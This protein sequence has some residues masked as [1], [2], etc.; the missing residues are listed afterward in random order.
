M[1]ESIEKKVEEL[2]MQGMGKR[3]IYNRLKKSRDTHKLTFYI[4]NIATVAARK[5]FQY[6][7]LL[8]VTPL[9]FI[10][11]KKLIGIFS[12]GMM[13]VTVLLSLVVPVI[14]IYVLREVLRFRRLG[15]QFLFIISILSLL[16]PENHFLP[17]F[18]TFVFMIIL[19]GYLYFHV[20]PKNEIIQ[21]AG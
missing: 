5:R 17:E 2:L 8:L 19:S 12:F 4:N 20:F 1:A 10:T 6:L 7:N 9:I 13:G 16:Q 15:Y 21:N 11:A 18:S 14:N 3:E